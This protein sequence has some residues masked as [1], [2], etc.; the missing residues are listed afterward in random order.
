MILPKTALT[1]LCALALAI[2]A[3]A[4][5]P[6]VQY[7]IQAK[8]LYPSEDT[9]RAVWAEVSGNT[10]LDVAFLQD[11]ALVLATDLGFTEASIEVTGD[12][13]DITTDGA[14]ADPLERELITVGADGLCRIA[15]S[16]T[17][18]AF[19]AESLIDAMA[20]PVGHGLWIDAQAVR[21]ADLD[22]DGIR[23]DLVGVSSDGRWFLM[24]A[25]SGPA[26]TTTAAL[27]ALTDP[28]LD[29]EVFDGHSWAGDETAILTSTRLYF[30]N[31]SGA[32][33]PQS[34]QNVN[35]TGDV[36]CMANAAQNRERLAW[37]RPL[38]GG[39]WVLSVVDLNS[40]TI[41]DEV[42]FS[43]DSP[44]RIAEGDFDGDGRSDMA[45]TNR[46]GTEVR[47]FFQ[48]TDGRFT[49]QPAGSEI[50]TVD[51][52]PVGFTS[53]PAVLVDFDNDGD[54]DIV[55]VNSEQQSIFMAKNDLVDDKTL[56]PTLVERSLTD[57][58]PQL[59]NTSEQGV[60]TRLRARV[61]GVA[62]PGVPYP[63]GAAPAGASHLEARLWEVKALDPGNPNTDYQTQATPMDSVMVPLDAVY[64]DDCADVSFMETDLEIDTGFDADN[65]YLVYS[66]RFVETVDTSDVLLRSWPH[67]SFSAIGVDN[68]GAQTHVND[69]PV[70]EDVENGH[71]A[72]NDPWGLELCDDDSPISGTDGSV[73]NT[74]GTVNCVTDFPPSPIADDKP[75]EDEEPPAKP[76][77]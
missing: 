17:L 28:V 29:I 72:S 61:H 4:Q 6:P 24:A 69:L 41:D 23:D 75:E 34:I 26:Y 12:F 37:L 8:A 15:W 66:L 54:A 52:P 59:L 58:R 16:E 20:D 63:I 13:T 77:E 51:G 27:L 40:V 3:G 70:A 30:V 21:P 31:S 50:Y 39:A 67:V 53:A 36:A 38:G 46:T 57:D 32:K 71:W 68:T 25:R 9:A 11:S 74:G 56:A 65:D 14:S 73:V 47:V 42:V 55:A 76:K 33:F 18:G 35:P 49:G 10:T 64:S 43:G 60:P 1:P 62:V 45:L 19:E 2:G 48:G 22:G 5:S 44:R 7:T